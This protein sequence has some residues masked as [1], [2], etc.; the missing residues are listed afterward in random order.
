MLPEKHSAPDKQRRLLT[1]LGND[2]GQALVRRVVTYHQQRRR[3]DHLSD[4]DIVS[5][6]VE[7]F[8]GCPRDRI[9]AVDIEQ[10]MA[11]CWRRE[12]RLH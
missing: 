5:F 10:G 9:A 11:V 3:G 12:Q 2:L 8:M 6:Y 1:C 7:Q 4:R